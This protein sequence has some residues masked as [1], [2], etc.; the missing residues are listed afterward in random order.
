MQIERFEDDIVCFFLVEF[1]LKA[2][3]YLKDTVLNAT[4]IKEDLEKSQDFFFASKFIDN[5]C[6][7]L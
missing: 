4:M 1:L 2:L 6:P 5:P 3:T 7:L